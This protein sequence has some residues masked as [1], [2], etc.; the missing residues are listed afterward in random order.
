MKSPHLLLLA[1]VAFSVPLR[2]QQAAPDR[3]LVKYKSADELV[4]SDKLESVVALQGVSENDGVVSGQVVNLS[5]RRLENINLSVT[6]GWRWKN[7]RH[8]GNDGP[9]WMQTVIVPSLQ[10]H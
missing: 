10:P 5:G 3:I 4:A 9:G 8:P 6:Y 7:E 1:L 2:A